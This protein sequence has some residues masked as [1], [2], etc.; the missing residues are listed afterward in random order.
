LVKTKV[1]IAILSIVI[2][3]SCSNMVDN[4]ISVENYTD[5]I[6]IEESPISGKQLPPDMAYGKIIPPSFPDSIKPENNLLKQVASY[7]SALLHG[8]VNACAKY[9]Y[10]DAFTYCRKFYPDF[11]DEE[12][13]KEFFKSASGDLQEHL[14]KWAEIGVEVKIIVSNLVRKVTKGDDIIIV[15]NVSTNMCSD[16]VFIHTKS[17]ERTIG[18]SQNGGK[19]WWFMC[20]HEDLPTILK[21]HYSDE[22]VDEVMGY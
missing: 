9:L 8:D 3:P 6:Q 4:K 22:V 19:N 17:T 20:D 15:F 5:S 10:P 11:P 13:M 16:D 7:N 12:V 1:L 2:L 18:I 21:M 14:A